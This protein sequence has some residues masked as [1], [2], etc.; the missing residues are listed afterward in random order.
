MS[1][2]IL[3]VGAGAIGGLFGG[4]LAQAGRDVTFLVRPR[5]AEALR[6]DGLRIRSVLGD[7]ALQPK[8]VT[9]D[10]LATPFDVVFLSVKAYALAAAMD[11]IAPAVGPDTLI[12]PVLNGMAHMD[13]LEK[14][15][16]SAALVGG[17]SRAV[18]QLDAQGA[19]EQ[20]A[21]MQQVLY[22]ELDGSVSPRIRALDAAFQGAGFDAALSTHIVQDMWDKWVMLASLGAA[23]CLL[24]GAIGEIVAQTGGAELSKEMVEDCAQI[25]AACGQPP[26]DAYR[27]SIVTTMTQAGSPMTSSMYRDMKA[28][29]P[30]EAEQILGDLVRRGKAAGVRSPLLQA[31]FVALQTYQAGLAKAG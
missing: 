4:R 2:S 15:F 20:L 11:D 21:P 31:A 10:A 13:Q 3:V 19:V 24:G 26:A 6:R 12:L 29:L 14:R 18:V 5:R 8:L 22:G 25:A 17:V 9:A 1:L 28:G 16:G 27:Q 30:V 7:L 23:T